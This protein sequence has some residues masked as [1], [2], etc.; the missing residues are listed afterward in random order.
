[1]KILLVGY[2]FGRGG[3]QTHTHYLAVG[4]CERGHQVTVVTP[5]PVSPK[6]LE[7]RTD[8]QYALHVYGGI[9]DVMRGFGLPPHDTAVVCGTGWKAMAG[10][11]ALPRG[12][13]RVFFE[14]MSGAR[15]RLL[16]PRI[17]IH[18]G[19]DAIVG[20]GTAVEGRFIEAFG[21]AGTSSTIPA[22]P[23]PLERTCNIHARVSR[24]PDDRSPVRF[25]YFGRLA[26][27]K[28]VALLIDRW[29]EY[30]PLG[31][32]LDIFGSGPEESALAK[33]I[34]RAGLG[35]SIRLCGRYPDGQEYVDLTKTF[36][37]KLLPTV[38]DEGAP[39]V[40]LEAMACGLPF[41]ANGVGGIPDYAN[42]DCAITSGDVGEFIPALRDMVARLQRGEIDNLRLQDFYLKGFSF[43]GLVDRW[44][45][46]LC[47]LVDGKMTA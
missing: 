27:H 45:S 5:A 46:F 22:L 47:N 19:F 33:R 35:Q 25:V 36:D 42:P 13:R 17:M 30:A 28:G 6:H 38:G 39:L 1:M 24:R 16:D 43:E 23:E 3:I 9:A 2:M 31:S 41:V 32:T 44:E 11:L 18:L 15:L 14:V 8:G 34:A 37:L 20:Q 21:W 29:N 7:L 26:A 4:L 40:L 10:V 12:C